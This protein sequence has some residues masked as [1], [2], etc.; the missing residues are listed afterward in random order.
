M[1]DH[2]GRII[3]GVPQWLQD[4]EGWQELG[5][6]TA[7]LVLPSVQSVESEEAA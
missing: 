2:N 3:L 4:Y 5:G 1:E 6:A 7:V